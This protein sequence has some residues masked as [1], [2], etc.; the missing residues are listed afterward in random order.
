MCV[1][2]VVCVYFYIV[3]FTCI[4]QVPVRAL[5]LRMLAVTDYYDTV[6]ASHPDLSVT[7]SHTGVTYRGLS[8]DVTAAKLA[9]LELLQGL[10]SET[11]RDVSSGVCCLLDKDPVMDHVARCLKTRGLSVAWEVVNGLV[12]VWATDSDTLAKGIQVIKEQVVQSQINLHDENK[13][14]INNYVLYKVVSITQH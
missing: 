12:T 3:Y 13:E 7:S 4:C 10:V 9:M 1:Y 5:R 11:I 2:I 14:V 8:G 6:S